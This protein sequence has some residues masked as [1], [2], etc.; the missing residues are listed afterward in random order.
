MNRTI[1]P[2]TAV[3]GQEK[4]KNALLWNIINPRI[5]GV[6]ISGEKGTAKST[7]VRGSAVLA[8]DMKIVELPLNITEDRLV[9]SID[10]KHALIHG[11][12]EL[13]PG[14]LKDADGNILYVDEVNLLSDHIINCLLEVAASGINHI[15]REGIS[16]S[17]DSRFILIGSMN[18]EE[19]QMRPQILDRFG[20]YVEVEGEKDLLQRMEIVRRRLDFEDDPIAFIERYTEETRGLAE[21]IKAAIS[22]L[23]KVEVTENALLLASTLT[24]NAFC[25]GHRGEICLIETAKAIAAFDGRWMLNLDDIQTAAAYALP[26]RAQSPPPPLPDELENEQ[27]EDEDQEDQET[28][29]PEEPPEADPPKTDE[30]EEEEVDESEEPDYLP[31]DFDST[32]PEPETDTDDDDIDQAE[33]DIQE[34]GELFVIPRWVSKPIPKKAKRGSGRRNVVRSGTN[35]GRYVKYRLAGEE[36]VNDLAFDATIRAAAAY[37]LVRDKGSRAI[38]IEHDDLR[39]K[40]REKRTG[41]CILFVVDASASMGANRRM[42]E[43]KAA[44]ISM[45]NVSYQKRDKVGLIAFRKNEAESLLSITRSVD[46]A[47]KNLEALPTGGKTPLAKGLDLAYEVIMGLKRKDP[48]ALP[49]L[50]LVTDGRASGSRMPGSNPFQDALKSAARIGNQNINTIVLDTENDFIRFHLCSELNEK[51]NGTL[52]TMEELKADGIVEAISRFR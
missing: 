39:V 9:G 36:R 48:D 45:L 22:I 32:P 20:L 28:E 33:D 51:L 25:A 19:G 29:S 16:L 52:I 34:A 15:E 50:V 8:G 17:H 11:K 37:Q 1:F 5:G 10:L 38:A 46:L 40:V 41:N 35:Q 26:H 21:R 27:Q 18:P 43:V 31:P 4:V 13:D 30:N 44:I 7:L 49:T 2:F 3:L 47:Q 23:P 12:R 14:V 42:T 24:E 6:L